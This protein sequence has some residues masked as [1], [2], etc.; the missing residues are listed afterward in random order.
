MENTFWHKQTRDN[1]LFPDLLWSRP[2]HKKQ[3]GKLLIIGGNVHS[4]SA[5]SEAY[6]AAITAGVGA[7]RV[8][9]PDALK[10]TV[11][12]LLENVEF[13]PS[14]PSGSFST[15]SLAEILEHTAWADGIL[16]AG[17]FGRNSE[18]AIL[19]EKLLDKTSRPLVAVKDAA[20]YLIQIPKTL[21]GRGNVSLVLTI[22]Q[23]QKLSTYLNY[24]KPVTFSMG[25]VQLVEFL[26]EFSKRFSLNLVVYHENNLLVAVDE[27]VSSTPV[28]FDNA[29][30]WR[31]KTATH[32]AIWLMQ[33]PDKPFEAISTSF[34]I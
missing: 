22:A 16:L 33:N 2:E 34:I 24:D 28:N 5:A 15:Q 7:V 10:K 26:H 6:Q 11:S 8:L 9:L 12:K 20:D 13:A 4:F 18:T 32:A 30:M 27:R 17:D 25:L 14:T 1:P 23:L 19:I 21:I 31:V 29:E 3:A